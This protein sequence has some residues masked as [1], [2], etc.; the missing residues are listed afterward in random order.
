MTDRD[1]TEFHRALTLAERA[2]L[3]PVL[4]PETPPSPNTVAAH[5]LKQWREL[6]PFRTDGWLSRRLADVGLDEGSL[7]QLLAVPLES[8][9]ARL[10][11]RPAW[12]DDLAGGLATPV[13]AE[14]LPLPAALEGD[15]GVAFL[16]LVRPLIA[17]ARRSLRAGI[18]RIERPPFDTMAVEKMLAETLPWQLLGIIGR[19]LVLEMHVARLQGFL[20]GETPG[21]RYAAFVER[22]RRPEI[23]AALFAEYPVL[24]R[25]ATES[26]GLWVN[27][28]LELLE[29]LAAD[30]PEIKQTFFPAGHPGT[31]TSVDGGAGDRHRGG[32]A[33]RVLGF[34][35]GARLV[36]KPRPLAADSHFQDLLAWLNAGGDLPPFRTVRVMDRGSYG[37]MEH[38]TAAGCAGESEV[39]LYHRRLGG[40]LALLYAL[41]ATDCHY[42]NLIAAGDQS[43]VVD[44]ESLFHPRM[45]HAASKRPDE[46]LVAYAMERSVLR[47]G[48]LPFRVGQ[49]EDFEGI[50][51]SGVS[52][53]AGLPSPQKVL[54]WTGAGTDEMRA[55]R[56]RV[57]LPGGHNRP[58][59]DGKDVEAAGYT[60][61]MAA[62]FADVYRLLIRRREELLAP[63]SPVSRFAGDPVRAVLRPTQMYGLLLTES[64]HPD[65]LRD[66]LDRDLLFD[67]LWV[68]IGEQPA[69]ARVIAAEHADL[70]GGDIPAF[71]ACPAS[72]DLWT[73][74]GERIAGFFSEPS[75][76]AVQ[77]RIATLDEADLERQATLIRLSL[78]T[79]LL[80]RD[81]LGDMGWAASTSAESEV[82]PMG[83]VRERLIAA[84]RSIGD[85]LSTLALRGDG[86]ATWI[87]LEYRNKVWSLSPTPEDLYAGLPGVALFLGHLGEAA[88]DAAAT[89]LAREA[90]AALRSRLDSGVD[91]ITNIGAFL[92]WGGILYTLAHLAV[93]WRDE[94]LLAAA[95]RIPQRIAARLEADEDCDVVGGAAGAIF[96]LL[97]FHAAESAG[98]SGDALA[99]AVLCGE[100][101]LARAQPAGA[102][103]GWLTRLATA[104]PQIGFSHGNAGIGLAL[105]ELGAATGET[106]FTETGLAA[107]AW[108]RD[109]F[110][111]E[112]A[113]W[114][115]R[116]DGEAP[117]PESTVAMA[118]CYGAPGVALSRL[119]ALRHLPAG[120]PERKALERELTDALH[121]TADRGFG[122]SHCLCHGDLGNL[123]V[124]LEAA[125]QLGA[126]VADVERHTAAV[127]AGIERHGPRCG[128]RGGVESPGLMN[129]LAGI[130]YGL[131]RLADPDRVPSVLALASPSGRLST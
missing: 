123:D 125:R 6:S 93:L 18:G 90:V 108:E 131:L 112:L 111:P 103:L 129:G 66:A 40:L 116:K 30:W 74:R 20:P 34:T 124:L 62:G 109:A 77:R 101:L 106:R 46:R 1:L 24:A 71:T 121:L 128:T 105:L 7:A 5:R 25:L 26:L 84:A 23:A 54:Q 33:V 122:Q 89:R 59:L 130:G 19:T 73:S 38:V 97:A 118:W 36:Y 48:L 63:G 96:G 80:N 64:F 28:S 45:D 4:H 100:R 113:R 102:G 52:S 57:P 42:E 47:I 91:E 58:Q 55:V 12:L 41:E 8:L 81:D 110:W 127:L 21:E 10:A 68:G 69:L 16:E 79:Q 43:V 99:T 75:F 14:P 35:S 13:S 87:G 95:E 61:E 15:P 27:A 60:A 72:V 32:R 3:H 78:G 29:R 98:S 85:R 11:T 92:G 117:P 2:A 49:S 86:L 67:R 104:E 114:M 115:D 126:S 83:K 50:D 70:H 94:E 37:W 120:R 107:F 88:G 22:L 31:L 44:L 82:V 9:A 119:R 17:Q 53:V 56:E 76:L 51:L 39:A 65:V